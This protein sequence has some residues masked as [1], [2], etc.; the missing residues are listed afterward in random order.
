M[1]KDTEQD[2][3]LAPADYWEHFLKPKLENF[4]RKKN[5]PL[6]SEDTT[7]MVSVTA[8]LERNL[9]K[10]FNDTSIEWA[11]IES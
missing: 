4:L 7:V 8:R 11:V 9:T 6:G 2:I 3:A 10:R 1:P 5:R